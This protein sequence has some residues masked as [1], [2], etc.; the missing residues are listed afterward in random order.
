MS[1]FLILG[2][3]EISLIKQVGSSIGS[4]FSYCFIPF[5]SDSSQSNSPSKINFGDAAVVSGEMVVSSPM[6]KVIG[7]E[8]YYFLT[9]E[10]FS[11]GNNRIEYG[12]G[13]N[14]SM[15]NI[16][17]DLGSP[18]TMLQKRLNYHVSSLLIID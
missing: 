13:T 8:D 11:V 15:K 17:I 12:E 16:V 5:H 4:K 18:L 6:V 2:R 7:R 1:H 10:A 3:G 9:L 14:V